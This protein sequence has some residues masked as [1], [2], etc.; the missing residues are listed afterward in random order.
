MVGLD[1]RFQNIAAVVVVSQ[2]R[3]QQDMAPHLIIFN[4][5]SK[6]MNKI[7]DLPPYCPEA[8]G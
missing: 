1:S 5:L 8:V 7:Q 3:L 6:F 4:K 2:I